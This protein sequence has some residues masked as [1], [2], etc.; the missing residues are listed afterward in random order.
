MQRTTSIAFGIVAIAGLI[1]AILMVGYAGNDDKFITYFVA[2]AIASGDGLVNL[3]GQKVEQ[4]ST[5]LFTYILALVASLT[6]RITAEVGYGVSTFFHLACLWP[7]ALIFRQFAMHWAYG[8]LILLAPPI[9]YWGASGMENSF[10]LFAT[11]WAMILCARGVEYPKALHLLA[12]ALLGAAL[13]LIRPEG[14]ATTLLAMSIFVVVSKFSKPAL[15]V[16]ISV[17]AGALS[18]IGLRLASG[19]PVFPLPVYSKTATPFLQDLQNGLTYMAVTMKQLPIYGLVLVIA[20][21]VALLYVLAR[22]LLTRKN[23]PPVTLLAASFGLATL[24]FC[25]VAGGDWMPYGRF[26]TVPTALATLLLLI[27]MSGRSAPAIAAVLTLCTFLGLQAM[28]SYRFAGVPFFG[29][30]NVIEEEYTGAWSD[31]R[32]AIHSRDIPFI[33]ALLRQIEAHPKQQLSIGSIQMGMVPY[34]LK[35]SATKELTFFDFRGLATIDVHECAAVADPFLYN[36]YKALDELVACHGGPFDLIY[37]LAEPGY[38]DGVRALGCEVV[39]EE[40]LILKTT[41]YPR[42]FTPTVFIARC[43]A[44][45]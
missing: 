22:A 18:A 2:D 44:S 14:I 9:L 13:P 23:V 31:N 32:N 40:K 30:F 38:I 42:T 3:N 36:P 21:A 1:L 16:A 17:A 34:Y 41:S 5:V 35:H 7:L 29:T 39:Y 11:L 10:Y 6:G 45:G 25:I 8:V 37:D 4:S 24:A 19:L 12:T 26:L 15:L 20:G 43:D 28:T 33:D 27:A